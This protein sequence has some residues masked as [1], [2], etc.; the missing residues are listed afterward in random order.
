MFNRYMYCSTDIS[1]C[2]SDWLLHAGVEAGT[3][4]GSLVSS[5]P[6]PDGAEATTSFIGNIPTEETAASTAPEEDAGKVSTVIIGS[7]P[8]DGTQP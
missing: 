4:G 2:Q 1:S 7:V 5:S 3:E 8:A 6:G